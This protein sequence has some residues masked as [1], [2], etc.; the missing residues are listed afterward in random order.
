MGV[1]TVMM[2]DETMKHGVRTEV[3]RLVNTTVASLAFAERANLHPA[4]K[5]CFVPTWNSFTMLYETP[6]VVDIVKLLS[7]FLGLFCVP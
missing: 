7:I 3:G 2:C 6:V 4:E 1:E 5:L